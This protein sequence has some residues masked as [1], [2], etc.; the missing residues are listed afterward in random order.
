[1]LIQSTISTEGDEVELNTHIQGSAYGNSIIEA[2]V[3]ILNGIK[4]QTSLDLITE[5]IKRF[6]KENTKE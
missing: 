2:V 5:A 3:A 4:N 6:A 1:M